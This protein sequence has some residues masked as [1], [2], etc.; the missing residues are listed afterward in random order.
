M[1]VYIEREKEARV[2]AR[3]RVRESYCRIYTNIFYVAVR[4]SVMS[5]FV[6]K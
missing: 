3:E 2:K 1:Y 4:D 6:N 5:F